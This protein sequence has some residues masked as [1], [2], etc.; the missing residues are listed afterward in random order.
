MNSVSDARV[1]LRTLLLTALNS[2]TPSSTNRKAFRPVS[3]QFV[4][5]CIEVIWLLRHLKP[6]FKTIAD[7]RRDYCGGS[8]LPGGGLSGCGSNSR[9]CGAISL[10]PGTEEELHD[11]LGR[12]ATND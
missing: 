11:C 3:R 6:D 5:L 7:F 12:F 1:K 4:L 10:P 9:R 8:R 2:P